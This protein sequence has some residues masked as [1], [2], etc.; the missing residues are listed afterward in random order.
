ML[1]RYGSKSS[2]GSGSHKSPCEFCNLTYDF[3]CLPLT[4]PDV[5]R[6]HA[7]DQHNVSLGDLCDKWAAQQMAAGA[8]AD[9]VHLLLW[10]GRGRSELLLAAASHHRLP[11]TRR[12]CKPH[13]LL[14]LVPL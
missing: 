7:A 4:L 10:L 6:C 14:S 13:R 12:L 8:A 2:R 5:A 1:A 9:C 11:L 3:P